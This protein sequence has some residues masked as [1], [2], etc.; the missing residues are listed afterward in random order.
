M[1]FVGLLVLVSWGV[2]A[3]GLEAQ[4]LGAAA[5]KERQ[6]REALKN[7]DWQEFTPPGGEFKVLFPYP[8]LKR[9]ELIPGMPTLMETYVA[10]KDERTY[11]ARVGE[12]PP[13]FTAQNPRE[14]SLDQIRDGLLQDAKGQLEKEGP[15]TLGGYSGRELWIKTSKEQGPEERYRARIWVTSARFFIVTAGAEAKAFES[16]GVERFLASFSILRP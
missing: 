3:T 2:A 1:R 10:V 9:R 7:A 8:P 6:R 15:V 16:A 4:A 12:L 5:A 11:L 13:G 14:R